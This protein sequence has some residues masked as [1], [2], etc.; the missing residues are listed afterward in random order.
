MQAVLNGLTITIDKRTGGLVGLAYTGVGTMLEADPAQCS[1]VDIACP[2]PGYEPMRVA[3]RYSRGALVEVEE[4]CVRIHCDALGASRKYAGIGG[5]ITVTVTLTA[6][7]DD[8]SVVMTCRVTNR[9]Q[10]PVRQVLFPDFMGLRPFAGEQETVFRTAGLAARPF[11]ELKTPDRDY[12]YATRLDYSP[13]FAR[14]TSGGMQAQPSSGMVL[15]WFDFGS[16]AGGFSLFPRKWGSEV[17]ETVFLHLPEA[18]GALRLMCEHSVTIEPGQAWDSPEYVLTPHTQGWAKG[19]EPYRDWVRQHYWKLHP[20]PE[21][22]RDGLGFRTVWMTQNAEPQKPVWRFRN[23]VQVARECRA[24]GLV[25]IVLWGAFDY[26]SVRD[27]QPAPACG[28]IEEFEKA[29]VDCAKLGVRLVPFV[30]FVL[31]YGEKASQRYGLPAGTG[32]NWTY[33]TELV[34]GF[35]A[36]YAKG[37]NAAV[38]DIS[39]PLWQ[40]DVKEWFRQ[41]MDRGVSSFSWDVFA[42]YGPYFTKLDKLPEPNLFTLTAELQAIMRQHDPQAAFSG[43]DVNCIEVNSAYLDYA[44]NWRESDAPLPAPRAAQIMEIQPLTSVLPT[45]RMNLNIDRSVLETKRGFTDNL[46]LNLWPRKPDDVN[47]SDR[48]ANHPELSKAL[49]QC[50]NLRKKFLRYFVE[51]TFVGECVLTKPAQEVQVRSYVMPDRMLTIVLNLGSARDVEISWD[52]AP[53]LT[54][55]GELTLTVF[56]ERGHAETRRKLPTPAEPLAVGLLGHCELKL[57]ETV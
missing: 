24:H 46:F 1:L 54:T 10:V 9:S 44:W 35:M 55:T 28:T 33:H 42:N 2:V 30:S 34:P 4:G 25:E 41:V 37:L 49:R 8:R 22:I 50:A 14:Y 38:V 36:Y 52:L 6:C 31:A 47:G 7:D 21:H 5:K 56:D 32:G 12:F 40:Q 26:T 39:L 11:I 18:T 57:L 29:V 48:I 16:L 15:R 17:I 53:W 20:L 3:T 27:F 19:I 43:E 51:G 13:N 45:P 23:L